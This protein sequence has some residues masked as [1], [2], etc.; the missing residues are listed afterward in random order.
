VAA[1]DILKRDRYSDT[2]PYRGGGK[3][4]LDRDRFDRETA[5]SAASLHNHP[6]AQGA[7]VIFRGLAS[8]CRVWT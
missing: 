2:L 3:W 5:T 6:I 1:R 7:I 4:R 8:W